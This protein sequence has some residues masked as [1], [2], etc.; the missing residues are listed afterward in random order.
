LLLLD[1]QDNHRPSG[2]E[3][4]VGIPSLLLVSSDLGHALFKDG[5]HGLVHRVEVRIFDKVGG[6]FVSDEEGVEFFV[7]NSGGDCRVVDSK[8]GGEL[9]GS[10]GGG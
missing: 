7:G 3:C 8:T 1:G 6:S 2:T 4:L 5:G 10:I 9:D